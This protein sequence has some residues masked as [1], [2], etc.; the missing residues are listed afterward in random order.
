MGGLKITLFAIPKKFDGHIGVIQRNAIRSWSLLEPRPDIILFGDDAGTEE[1]ANE[2]GCLHHPQA[3][4]NEY[5][6]PLLNDMFE[7]AHVLAPGSQFVCYLNSDIM[8]LDDFVPG[9]SRVSMK[10]FLFVSHRWDVDITEPIEFTEGWGGNVRRKIQE[11]ATLHGPT[12]IDLFAFPFGLYRTIPAFAVGRPCWDN[13]MIYHARSLKI[14][15]I[16]AT[17]AVTLVHQNHDY[18]HRKGGKEAIWNGP[19]AQENLRLAGGSE[20]V[21]T[22]S[23]TTHQL[24]RE[25]LRR[26]AWRTDRIDREIE[27]RQILNPGSQWWL[28]ILTGVRA[29]MPAW[30]K[31]KLKENLNKS[32]V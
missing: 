32:S 21:F 30:L 25:G 31:R 18:S 19:E 2:F 15:V 10:Q 11:S 23:D 12:G 20:H 8:L 9:I 14:P 16:D 17:P 24:T 13:W 7:K 1:A 28:K 22:L 5:G 4:R 3:A 29:V 6:T 27:V 26:V